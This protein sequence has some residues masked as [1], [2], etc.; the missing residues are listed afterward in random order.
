M[1]WT[2]LDAILSSEAFEEWVEKYVDDYGMGFVQE[3]YPDDALYS[4]EDF[5][6]VFDGMKPYDIM[7][8]V[9]FG[10]ISLNDSYFGFNG[11]GNLIS[12]SEYRLHQYLWDIIRYDLENFHDYLSTY[13]WRDYDG[14]FED[15]FPMLEEVEEVEEGEVAV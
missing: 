3:Y 8:R 11:Y 10:D 5:D 4:F 9:Y 6:E 13:Y 1:A 7:C 14:E 12:V 15:T 2:S